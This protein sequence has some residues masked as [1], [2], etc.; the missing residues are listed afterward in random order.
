MRLRSGTQTQEGERLSG[1]RIRRPRALQR[2][3]RGARRLGGRTERPAIPG[4]RPRPHCSSCSRRARRRAVG[5]T[6]QWGR[7]V[8]ELV[9]DQGGVAEAA[10]LGTGYGS[11]P[12]R[13]RWPTGRSCT[14]FNSTTCTPRGDSRRRQVVPAALAVDRTPRRRQR[15]RVRRGYRLPGNS[16]WRVWQVLKWAPESA[17]PPDGRS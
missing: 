13:L 3:D 10:V 11:L 16:P 7:I 8:G 9:I 6:T 4:R 14:A 17:S 1:I 15:P 5:S 2:S 12:A